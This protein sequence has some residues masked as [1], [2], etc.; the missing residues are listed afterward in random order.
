MAVTLTQYTERKRVVAAGNNEIWYEDIDVAAGSMTELTDANGDIDTTDQLMLTPAFQQVFVVNGEKLKVADFVSTK[1]TH[2]A[3]ATPHAFGD[4]LT[5]DQ[6]GGDIA[7]MTV[8]YTNAAK[9]LTYGYAFYDGDATAFNTADSVT[10]SGDGSSFTPSAVTAPPHWHD[11]T[12]YQG[13]T[14]TYGTMPN[15]AYISCLYN[16][17]LVLAGNPEAPFQW[18]MS[19]H[20]NPYDWAYVA[21]DDLT[22]IYGGVGDAGELGD[23]IKALIPY[24]DDFL[25]FGCAS[26]MWVLYGDAAKGGEIRE[27]DLTTGIF[28]PTAYCWDNQNRLYFWGNSG[29][30]RTSIPGTPV[31]IS[32]YKLPRL[33]KDEAADPTTHRITLNYDRDRHGIVVAITKLSDGSNSNYWYDLNAV[34]DNEIGALF[35]ET[36]PTQCGIYSAMYYDANDKSL[37]GGIY[38]GKD[39]YIRYF[40][41]DAKS[42]D[43]GDT[44]Q[45][46]NS[47]IT[48]GPFA[49]SERARHEGVINALDIVTAGGGS[50]GSQSDS[51]DIYYRIYAGRTSAKILELFYTDTN[52]NIAGTFN[53]PGNLRGTTRRQTVREM[54]AGIKLGNSTANQSWA[55]EDII[56]DIRE[57]GRAK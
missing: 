27:L 46:I 44:D 2:G 17:R 42:D 52:P 1:L 54:W 51:D 9:T 12:V 14:T 20:K 28:G 45:A 8:V 13:D 33:V 23:I 41:D 49:L 34:D 43:I 37:Q 10:G 22:P 21:N 15:K 11:W 7:Y 3:L 6:G 56:I 19:R 26:T 57:S 38:G 29:L 32:R 53:G 48:V 30:Y 18:Y 24:K 47:Y 36:Y 55:I 40:D 35:P 39:G 50:G 16:G 31:C 5:Q 25:V 4:L